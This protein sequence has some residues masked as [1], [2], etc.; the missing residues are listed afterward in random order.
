MRQTSRF[1]ERELK[2]IEIKSAVSSR[3]KATIEERA[4]GERF[5]SRNAGIGGTRSRR[6]EV[7]AK[8]ALHAYP[9]FPLHLVVNE[10][11]GGVGCRSVGLESLN[12]VPKGCKGLGA[13]VVRGKR[14][15][16]PQTR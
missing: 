15:A 14:L 2:A 8:K 1:A 16:R 13:K 4:E 6:R 3:V 9:A 5:C 12:K 7:K 10:R 11:G